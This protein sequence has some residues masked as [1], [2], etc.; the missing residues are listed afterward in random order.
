MYTNVP[1]WIQ[2]LFHNIKDTTLIQYT[3]QDCISTTFSILNILPLYNILEQIFHDDIN[4]LW[5]YTNTCVQDIEQ[6]VLLQSCLCINPYLILGNITPLPQ[7]LLIRSTINYFRNI[8]IESDTIFK[9]Y[10]PWWNIK[11]HYELYKYRY[12]L[13]QLLLIYKNIT[14]IPTCISIIGML[15]LYTTIVIQIIKHSIQELTQEMYTLQKFININTTNSNLKN[16]NKFYKYLS[17]YRQWCGL[18]L[19]SYEDSNISIITKYILLWDTKY[20]NYSKPYTK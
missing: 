18:Q 12:N 19:E 20:D 5:K 10:I 11:Q 13:N 8:F 2:Y 3:I 15:P 6:K 17:L 4:M 14:Y 7:I 16:I 1:P 9:K